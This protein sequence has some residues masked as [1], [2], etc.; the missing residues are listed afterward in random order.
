MVKW[1]GLKLIIFNVHNLLF[2]L[3]RGINQKNKKS[4][5]KVYLTQEIPVDRDTG[6]PKYNVLG[7]Q[8]YGDIVTLLP[9]LGLTKL[10]II[11]YSFS[12]KARKK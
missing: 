3:K 9:K 1:L 7:A 4:M 11:L 2:F 8:K 6:Q 5:S 10:I 12:M